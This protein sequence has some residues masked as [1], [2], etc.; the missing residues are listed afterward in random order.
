MTPEEFKERMELC[1]LDRDTEY[2]HIT[3][4]ELMCD[5][6]KELGYSEGVEIF[7]NMHKWYA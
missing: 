5:V 1:S 7:E 3:A 6:L 2:G 4:D